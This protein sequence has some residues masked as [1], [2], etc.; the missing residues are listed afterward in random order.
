MTRRNIVLLV[1]SAL[2]MTVTTEAAGQA[3]TG[4][5]TVV[6]IRARLRSFYF[7]LAHND[8]EALTADILP[9]KVVAH[10]P[11]PE[12]LLQGLSAAACS[13]RDSISLEQTVITTDGDW[14]EAAVPHC[15]GDEG[16]DQFRFIRFAG[17]WRIVSIDLLQQPKATVGR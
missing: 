15:S 7:N 16:S 4:D 2:V 13:S 8:W 5:D 11:P 6:E 3:A 1:A 12:S 9:A 14:A 17:R 10:R